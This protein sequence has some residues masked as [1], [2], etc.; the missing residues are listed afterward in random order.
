MTTSRHPVLTL[1]ISPA[2]CRTHSRRPPRPSTWMLTPT[3]A[4]GSCDGLHREIGNRGII[5][6][7]RN[8]IEHG[9]H[10]VRLFYGTPSPGNQVARELHAKNRFS[11]TRQVHYS[12]RN[13]S[14]SLD[15]VLF[16]NGLPI[17]T[18][19]LKNN[20]TKQTVED[21][22]EQYKRDRDPR[23]D[24]FRPG[25][26]TAHHGGRRNRAKFSTELSGPSI[27]LPALRQ[28]TRRRSRQPA[29]PPRS[30][31]RLP[32]AG[33]PDPGEP[34]GHYRK[35]CPAGPGETDLAPLSSVGVSAPNSLRRVPERR[36]KEIPHPALGRERQVQLY[37]MARPPAHRTQKDTKT[38]FDSAIIVTDRVVLD[39]QISETVSSSPR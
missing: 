17:I 21:A 5:D 25:R 23:E 28:G 38:I 4:S 35:L 12:P 14:L 11:V 33:D 19:E 37:R 3:P 8:G 34:H 18:F 9:Q 6:V 32:L 15:L 13:P 30:P 29:Q 16:I 10:S 27:R 7:L 39:S 2:S 24:I 36:R 26:C 22:V 20:L 1:A 31:H